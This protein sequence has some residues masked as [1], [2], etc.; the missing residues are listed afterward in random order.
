MTDICKCRI[1][2]EAY[3]LQFFMQLSVYAIFFCGCATDKSE[4]GWVMITIPE[5][6]L[7]M[8]EVEAEWVTIPNGSFVYGS[9][10]TQVCRVPIDRQAEVIITRPYKMA[11]TE[12]TQ[13]QWRMNGFPD[14]PNADSC[15][16][17]PKGFVSWFDALA[18]LN[19]LSRSVGLPECYNL[20]NCIGDPASGCPEGTQYGCLFK[21]GNSD[22]FPP[23]F[24]CE[25]N[26]HVYPKRV[27]CPGYRLPTA[28]EWERA[29]RGG[30]TTGTYLGEIMF[31]TTDFE[32]DQ[33]EP[34]IDSIAW[35]YCNSGEVLHPV[36][37]LL[38]NAYGLYDMLGN[39][40]EWVD[41]IF[42]GSSILSNSNTPPPLI[43][44]IGSS[45]YSRTARGMR[46]G[47]I[48]YPSCF[49]S[50]SLNL[51]DLSYPRDFTYGLRPVRT[52]FEE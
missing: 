34:M 18:W 26:V 41:D 11:S 42:N 35:H 33:R 30:T 3:C 31:D 24:K 7:E 32:C 46:G 6:K 50:V 40:W 23:N 51:D 25:G 4:D 47:S 37:E 17:C 36:G 45:D 2:V 49:C 29:A 16:N 38:P 48:V 44:P 9:P 52:I 5:I 12:I 14:S 8:E 13:A 28:A 10:E 15:D 20:S 22:H 27:D 19:T 1:C 21:E 39:A 43:D